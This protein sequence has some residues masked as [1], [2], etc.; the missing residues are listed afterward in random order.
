MADAGHT[1]FQYDHTVR[2]PA[3][4]DSRMVFFPFGIDGHRS[5]D[6]R[7]RTLEDLLRS[8]GHQ[9]CD[10]LILKMDVE[11]SEWPV[12]STI[13]EG[14]LAQFTQIVVELHG[15]AKLGSKRDWRKVEPALRAMTLNHVPVHIHGN[16]CSRTVEVNGR[17]FPNVLEVTL[18]RKDQAVFADRYCSFPTE[19]DAPN[20]PNLPEIILGRFVR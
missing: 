10:D 16:N 6:G 13:G 4:D 8:N 9:T 18:L 7:M 12:L 20:D 5:M 2:D 15:L 19:L 3:P 1:V 17:P 11:G 14:T